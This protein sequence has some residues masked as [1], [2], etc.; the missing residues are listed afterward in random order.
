MLA[1]GQFLEVSPQR[2]LPQVLL[3][4]SPPRARPQARLEDSGEWD[5]DLM[6]HY[7][8]ETNSRLLA[9]HA[10][11]VIGKI[12]FGMPSIILSDIPVV[13]PLTR[14]MLTKML[15]CSNYP[16]HHKKVLLAPSTAHVF[17]WAKLDKM[18]HKYAH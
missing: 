17:A 15:S 5:C 1:P 18:V 7:F 16:R 8:G 11:E 13:I 4:V 6:F 9:R 10:L 2:D 3:E 12:L 14:A